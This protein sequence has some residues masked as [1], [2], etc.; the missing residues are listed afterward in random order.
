M[1]M[2]LVSLPTS[3][4]VSGLAVLALLTAGCRSSVSDFQTSMDTPL[5]SNAKVLKMDGNWGADPWRCWEIAP[6]DD[7]LK[8][9]LVA[10]WK[11]T[12]NPQA[13]HGVASGDRI[14]CRY[15]DLTESYSGNSDSYRAVGV[16]LTR[17]VL[18]VYFY[19]G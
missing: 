6:A 3:R 5:P 18:I 1:R 4:T 10:R 15:E 14:C 11:L 2:S 17:K 12:P 13:F 9:A 8:Q 19:N 7:G 16:D